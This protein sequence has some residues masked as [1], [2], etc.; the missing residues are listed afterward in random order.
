MDGLMVGGWGRSMDSRMVGEGRVHRWLDG[1]G[2][3][4][5]M[6]GWLCRTPPSQSS[7]CY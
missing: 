3:R 7:S 1:W 5:L 4:T 6:V 2:G